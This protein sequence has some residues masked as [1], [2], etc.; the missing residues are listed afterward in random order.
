[1]TSKQVSDLNNLRWEWEKMGKILL[2]LTRSANLCPPEV[3]VIVTKHVGQTGENF[4]LLH[5]FLVGDK[6]QVSQDIESEPRLDKV[7]AAVSNAFSDIYPTAAGKPSK[8]PIND[9]LVTLNNMAAEAAKAASII[10]ERRVNLL[11]KPE[12][13][14][15]DQ[16]KWIDEC[17]GDLDGYVKRYGSKKDKGTDRCHGEGGEAIYEADIDALH[18]LE[19]A[20]KRIQNRRATD[21]H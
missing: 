18:R 10:E 6:W 9:E 15:E 20:V 14:L 3:Y 8:F 17:G 12:K 5:Y 2:C 1:M 13:Q 16:R 19:Q 21:K 11:S 7:L 4:S